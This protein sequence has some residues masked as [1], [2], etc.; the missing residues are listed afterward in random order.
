MCPSDE[1]VEESVGSPAEGASPEASAGAGAPESSGSESASG[2]EGDSSSTVPADAGTTP[3][4]QPNFKLKVMDQEK[5]IPEMFRG[6]MKDAESEKEIRRVFEQVYGFEFARQKHETTVGTLNQVQAE[7]NYLLG[8]V[9]EAREM[10]QRGDLDAFFERL[11]I[12]PQRILQYAMEK[13]QYQELPQEQRAMIDARR[14]AERQ[15]I[16]LQRQN[17]DYQKG[18]RDQL[19]Q[20]RQT[21]LNFELHRPE[22]KSVADSFDQRVGRPG[23]FVQEVVNRGQLAW[24]QSQGKVDLSPA[25]AIQEVLNLYGLQGKTGTPAQPSAAAGSPAPA[26]Q[27]PATIPNVGSGRS[28]APLKTKPKS[29]DDIRKLAAAA[30][31][32]EAV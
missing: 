24:M 25:Q 9:Q 13:L 19:V 28:S 31:S 2:E 26:V 1:V 20:H 30:A 10:Y 23:A 27:R 12:P 32:G 16:A 3:E 29:I 22:I 6:L 8:Q 7:H 21:A 5:E 11:A 15:N 18:M 17:A 4:Y 14:T